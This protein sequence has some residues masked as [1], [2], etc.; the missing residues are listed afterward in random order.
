MPLITRTKA[1]IMTRMKDRFTAAGFTAVNEVGSPENAIIE[2]LSDELAGVYRSVEYSHD[3]LDLTKTSGADLDN[4]AAMFGLKRGANTIAQ[5]TS[6]TNVKIFIDPVINKTAATLAGEY[7]L[8]EITIPLGTVLTANTV[9]YKTTA[10]ATISGSE[11]ET[12]VPVVALGSGDIY[13][14]EAG[15]LVVHNLGSYPAL[16]NLAVF[17]KCTNLLPISSG[18]NSETDSEFRLRVLNAH[19]TAATSNTFA[20]LTAARSVPGVAD[21]AIVPYIY[22]SGTL[23]VFIESTTP[24]VSPGLIRSVQ[25]TVDT[26]K[27]GGT[28]VYVQYPDYKALT[29]TIESILRTGADEDAYGAVVKPAVVNYINNL[30][31]GHSFVANDLL[32][33][34]SA[35]GIAVQSTIQKIKIGDYNI[36]TRKLLNVQTFLATTQALAQTEKWYTN[37]SLIDLCIVSE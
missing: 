26:I 28:R 15:E 7:N 20:I 14:I 8:N 25:D 36:Y 16:T 29:I 9:Q 18:Q 33:I 32:P 23:A 4:F 37:S 3:A 11:T 17:L 22:G 31:R 10:A 19:S 5:D 13:N 12:F 24:I 35:N 27:A 1:E 21:A 30:P 6:L 34:L 2:G